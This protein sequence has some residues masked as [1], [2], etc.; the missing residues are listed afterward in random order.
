VTPPHVEA[1]PR[2]TS[3]FV[4]ALAWIAVGVPLAWGVYRTLLTA[5]KLF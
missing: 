2:T 1:T 4:V 5:A 3:G